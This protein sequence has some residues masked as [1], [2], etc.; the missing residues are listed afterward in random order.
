MATIWAVPR[1]SY[2]DD[3]W[4]SPANRPSFDGSSLRWIGPIGGGANDGNP[5]QQSRVLTGS[6][7]ITT[8]AD[9]Q[10]I[11]GLNITGKVTISHSGVI[12]KQCRIAT[13]TG[14]ASIDITLNSLSPGPVI[15]DCLVD[16]PNLHAINM[17]CG[18]LQRCMVVHC[19]DNIELVGSRGVTVRDCYSEFTAA[20]ILLF[21]GAHPDVC[22]ADGDHQNLSLIHNVFIN[23]NNDNSSFT[24]GNFWGAVSNLVVTNNKFLGGNYSVYIGDSDSLGFVNVTFTN[25]R[26]KL[27]SSGYIAD[28]PMT[29][30]VIKSGNVDNDTGAPIAGF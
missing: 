4:P 29:G 18:T 11:E 19:V 7:A 22:E 1:P 15:R 5:V 16:G 21:P 10:V 23:S 8:S 12:V 3:D 26:I 30:T 14:P 13:G 20:D 2:S 25:N 27:G 28:Y 6:G 9:N 17:L 24:S